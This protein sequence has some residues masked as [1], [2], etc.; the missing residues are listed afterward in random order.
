[1]NDI[2]H[3]INIDDIFVNP[4]QP[5]LNFSDEKIEEL[6]MS[7]A[8]DGLIQPI[9]V[10]RVDDKFELVAGERRFR[11]TKLLKR[12]KIEAIIQN[13]DDKTS[14]RIAIIENIQRE[15]LS[16]VEEAIAF[17]KL[18]KDHGYSQKDL[19]NSLG[20]SQS[21]IANK[22]RL[23]GLPDEIKDNI[24]DKT[25][26][27]RHGRALLKINDTKKQVETMNKI[28]KD[29]LNVAKAE[30]YINRS[31]K[32]KNKP[33]KKGFISS[34]DYRLEINTIKQSI[35]L[36]KKAG[37]SVDYDIVEDDEGVKVDILIKK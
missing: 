27:E 17:E 20:K 3:L 23:L 30:E 29:N 32:E 10:R 13:Y 19:A 1:M 7:I 25:I 31:L 21:T 16:A 35:E 14:A 26:T 34:K 22:I 6:A 12:E 11:A 9:V 28:V 4:N 36:I 24:V 37:T 2:V 5:R 33:I 18:I 8:Q 15:N